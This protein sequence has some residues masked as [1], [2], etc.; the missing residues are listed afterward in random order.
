[1]KNFKDLERFVDDRNKK[2][3]T[4]FKIIDDS[5]CRRILK[6]LSSVEK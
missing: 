2:N 4:E 1:M 3:Y 5:L 6:Y